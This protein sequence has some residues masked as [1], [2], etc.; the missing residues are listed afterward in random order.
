MFK[1]IKNLDGGENYMIFSLLV[2]VVFFVLVGIY[3]MKVSKDRTEQMK[4]LPLN[5]NQE[6]HV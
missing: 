1:Q 3:L 5:D 6:G 4:Q 2:F